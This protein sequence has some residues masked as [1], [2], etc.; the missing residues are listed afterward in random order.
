MK[1]IK[2]IDLFNKIAKGEEVPEKI[3]YKSSNYIYNWGTKQYYIEGCMGMYDNS[4]R[5]KLTTFNRLN[6]EVEIIEE[7]K[8]PKRCCGNVSFYYSSLNDIKYLEKY[9]NKLT[10][11]VNEI[12]GYLER[13]EDD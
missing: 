11:K 1:T 9:V 8:I 6:D 2:I 4:L 5:S 3:I 10:N 7:N 12:I 13:K